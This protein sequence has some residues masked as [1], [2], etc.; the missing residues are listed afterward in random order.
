MVVRRNELLREEEEVSWFLWV[1]QSD[2]T[3]VPCHPLCAFLVGSIAVRRL[4]LVVDPGAD[5]ILM[6]VRKAVSESG[7]DVYEFELKVLEALLSVSSK[8]LVR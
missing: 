4:L 6:E 5:S 8:R 3:L 7:D 2:F 1:I